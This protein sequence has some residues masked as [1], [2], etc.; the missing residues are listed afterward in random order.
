MRLPAVVLAALLLVPGILG[1]PTAMAT[2]ELARA[3]GRDGDPVLNAVHAARGFAPLWTG[4]RAAN[5]RR[6]TLLALLR[7]EAAAD[8]AAAE[9]TAL[10][11][12]AASEIEVVATEIEA[13]RV[14]LAYVARRAGRD[15]IDPNT[16]LG[17][18]RWVDRPPPESPLAL[19]LL[20]LE[21]VRGVGGWRE[22]GTVPGPLPTVAPRAVVSP[23]VDV[24]PRLPARQTLPEPVSL[25]QRL[26]QSGDLVAS[27]LDRPDMDDELIAAVRRFQERQGL[28]V[29][30]V[31]GSRTLAAL[32]TPVQRQIDQVRLNIARGMPDRSHLR[33]YVEVNVPGFEL[34]VVVDGVV[35]LRSRVIVGEKD[36][37]TPIFDDW[38]RY[39]EINPSWYVPA[40][41]VPEL[42]EKEAA[43][44]GYLASDGFV[45]RGSNGQTLVQKP[46]PKNALGR[47]KF[48]FPNHHAVYLHDTPQRGLFGRSQRSLSHGCVRVEKPND[49]AMALLGEQGWT[50]KRLDATYASRKTQR[51]E[52]AEPVPVFLDYRTAFVGEDGRLQLRP[53]LYRHDRDG[54]IVFPEKGLPPAAPPSVAR[55]APATDA[56]SRETAMGEA[57]A[58]L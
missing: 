38:I 17:A 47:I 7:A 49:L 37:E 18:M 2:D 29:D 12:G 53:D 21:V 44:P 56:A 27:Q 32:N 9:P 8:P 50:R 26:V 48:L 34:K 30:G 23:E 14:A 57:P 35:V 28:L 20:E 25:R 5:Q 15:T 1:V 51:V 52:L 4:G 6:R 13:T 40:S 36:N 16:A 42:I 54:V 41:I 55:R 39:I 43:R 24:A 31:V 33:R 3:A 10:E 11:V 19:A 58:P 46:G 45:W 22:V